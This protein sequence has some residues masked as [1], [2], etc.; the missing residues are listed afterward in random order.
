MIV[1]DGETRPALAA[2]RS[3]GARGVPVHVLVEEPPGLAGASRFATA[4]HAAP[5]AEGDPAAWAAALAGLVEQLPGALVLP[6]TEVSVGTC[7]ALGLDRSLAIALPPRDAY[8]TATDKHALL[9]EATACGIPVPRST[10]VERAET[11]SGLPPGHAYPVIVKARR[12]RWLEERGGGSRGVWRRGGLWLARSDADLRRIAGEPGAQGGVLVQEWVPGG[13]AGIFFLFDRGTPRAR[14]A[15][16]R[17]REKPPS[18]GVGVLS[19]AV[20]PDPALAAK[21]EALL[22]RLG[23]HGVAMVEFRRATDGRAW[24]MEVNPRLW[25]SLQLAIDAGVDFP[26]ML[27]ALERGGPLPAATPRPGI[28]T[29]WLLG[30]LDRLWILLRDREQRE[31][32][33]QGPLAALLQFARGFVDG[34]HEEVLRWSDPRPF[35]VELRA[36]RRALRAARAKRGSSEPRGLD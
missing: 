10:L 13:G 25:G 29:R 11:L 22:R 7:F 27:V 14:F 16:R 17:L 36:W 2:V 19:E 20:E 31:A 5:S 32:V 4:V 9:R 28:R 30:D 15:H 24:L 3:L 35:A 8:E 1:T 26:A 21:S 33:G 34:S 18:G 23:W 6:V 12:S